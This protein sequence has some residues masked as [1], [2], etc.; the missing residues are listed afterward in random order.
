MMLTCVILDRP[1]H[2]DGEISIGFLVPYIT[3]CS[4]SGMHACLLWATEPTKQ[5][6]KF[7][8]P[9]TIKRSKASYITVKVLAEPR[10]LLLTFITDSKQSTG[11]F[12]PPCPLPISKFKDKDTPQEELE[13]FF[14]EEMVI[15]GLIW[16]ANEAK[17]FLD[18]SSPMTGPYLLAQVQIGCCCLV[19]ES[20]LTLL[21]PH[22]QRSPPGSSVHGISQARIAEWVAI[23]FSRGSS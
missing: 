3:H 20:Y 19:P 2:A 7:A 15:L 22:G 14:T 16:S 4:L 10:C 11:K 5:S 9:L 8:G 1:S 17:L 21:R 12:P 6:I 18:T 13:H 23:S